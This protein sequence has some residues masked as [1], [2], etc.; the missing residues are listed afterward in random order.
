MCPG[1]TEEN[2]RPVRVR[3]RTKTPLIQHLETIDFFG[4]SPLKNTSLL[5]QKYIENGLST[6]QIAAE[7]GV[8]RSA[9]KERLR[10][11]GILNGRASRAHYLTGQVPFGWKK[12]HGQL[13]PHLG[14]QRTLQ[15]I[16]GLRT[17]GKSLRGIAQILNSKSIKPKN[18]ETWH[19]ETVR[20]ALHNERNQGETLCSQHSKNSCS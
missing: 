7:L 20:R 12:E 3:T 6:T 2:W 15:E 18:G 19:A 11:I 10:E 4:Q 16:R 8:S 1:R 5:T 9:V 17:A 13:V 14:E